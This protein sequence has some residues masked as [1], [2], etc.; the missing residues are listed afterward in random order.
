MSFMWNHVLF[1]L[2]ICH[3][4]NCSHLFFVA[5]WWFYLEDCRLH[6]YFHNFVDLHAIPSYLENYA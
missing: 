1:M 2:C 4:F 5:L 3:M 6:V